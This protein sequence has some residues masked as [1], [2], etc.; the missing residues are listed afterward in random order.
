MLRHPRYLPLHSG[1]E[2]GFSLLE[3]IVAMV[4]ISTVGMAV[5]SWVNSNIEKVRRIN[6]HRERL[7]VLNNALAFVETINPMADRTGRNEMGPYVIRWRCT[8]RETSKDGVEGSNFR[9]E[10]F[11]TKVTLSKEAREIEKFE[12]ILV[13]YKAKV[14]QSKSNL[15]NQ[16]SFGGDDLEQKGVNPLPQTDGG[17]LQ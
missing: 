11:D 2:R 3:V 4:L 9:L 6:D 15:N 17:G 5:F 10:L 8:P 16:S 1:D 12:V 14:A 7:H 13:G